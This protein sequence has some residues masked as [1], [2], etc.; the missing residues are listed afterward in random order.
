MVAVH[1]T[2]G[3]LL[4]YDWTVEFYRTEHYAIWNNSVHANL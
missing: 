1:L 3:V 4:D 2:G